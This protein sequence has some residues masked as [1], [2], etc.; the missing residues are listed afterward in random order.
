MREFAF[1]P[2][3]IASL[4]CGTIAESTYSFV[5]R[6]YWPDILT[7]ESYTR[8]LYA[9]IAVFDNS[10]PA[11]LV[12][13]V[14]LLDK[15]ACILLVLVSSAPIDDYMLIPFSLP[16]EALITLYR[17]RPAVEL[18]NRVSVLI[19]VAVASLAVIIPLF[20]CYTCYTRSPP[21]FAY[22]RITWLS[23]VVTS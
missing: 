18:S 20:T 12:P 7:E 10:N 21:S 19:S 5:T 9:V 14:R 8:V 4:T 2:F 3:S 22:A 17:A 1:I 13:I 16:I 15:G 11:A 6:S 23:S